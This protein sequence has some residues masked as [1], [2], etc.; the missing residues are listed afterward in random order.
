MDT[1]PLAEQLRP[2]SFD[3]VI[4]QEHLVGKDGVLRKMLAQSFLPSLVFWGP[5]GV[6][7]TTLARLLATLTNSHFE[8]KSAVTATLADVRLIVSQARTRKTETGERTILFLDELHRFNKAQQDALLPVVE[9]GTICF[10]GATTENP[11]FEVIAPLLSRTRVLVLKQLT[12]DELKKLLGKALEFVSTTIDTDAQG[13]LIACA[14]GDGRSLLTIFEIAHELSNGSEITLEL[15]ETAAQKK[16][17]SYDKTGDNHYDTISAFI[18]S[19]RS[20]DTSASIYYLA[21]M[22]MSGEDPLF[23]ARR[24]VIFASEDIGMAQP[25]A[26]VV[27]NAVFDACHKVGYPEAHI[28]LA[29]GVV[30]LSRA[31]KNRSAYDALLMAEV[32]VEKYGN[33]PIPLSVRNAPTKLMKSLGYSKGY[34]MYTKDSHL[35]DK[36]K[37]TIYYNEESSTEHGNT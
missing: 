21:R 28:V 32:D 29:H 13:F 36:I 16:M 34:E 9:D 6:G 2:Q 35:P 33:L 18:K 23:I 1:R 37:G 4:G 12:D 17:L 8:S 15:V 24:M 11:S 25:T 26:L 20:S 27:A 31:K 3:D 5:P 10:I 7:K 22:T 30:Y 14:N 19:M